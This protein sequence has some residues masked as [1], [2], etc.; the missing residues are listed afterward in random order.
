MS[1]DLTI[2]TFYGT[3]EESVPQVSPVKVAEITSKMQDCFRWLATE[4]ASQLRL[5]SAMQ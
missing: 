1:N 4:G 3:D 5:N 2:I